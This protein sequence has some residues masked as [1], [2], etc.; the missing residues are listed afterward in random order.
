M[1]FTMKKIF[2]QILYIVCIFKNWDIKMFELSLTKLAVASLDKL[3]NNE[4]DV[5]SR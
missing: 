3:S 2:L 5:Y 4:Q 1:Y